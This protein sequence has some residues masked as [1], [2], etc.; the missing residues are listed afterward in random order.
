[1]KSDGT[2]LGLYIVKANVEN[3]GGEVGFNSEEGEETVFW[4]TLPI[5]KQ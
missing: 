4:F 3:N 2:G 1:M 5:A